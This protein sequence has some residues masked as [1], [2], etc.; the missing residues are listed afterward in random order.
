[1]FGFK[2]KVQRQEPILEMVL[3]DFLWD[4]ERKL[5]NGVTEYLGTAQEN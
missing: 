2:S 1:M 4:S 3:N 5:F